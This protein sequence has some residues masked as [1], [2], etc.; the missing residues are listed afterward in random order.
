MSVEDQ[1]REM[2]RRVEQYKRREGAKLE[3]LDKASQASNANIAAF[4][5]NAYFE[6]GNNTSVD[7]ARAALGVEL[8]KESVLNVI[9]A[10]EWKLTVSHI[11]QILKL[12]RNDMIGEH[13][14]W[15]AWDL[16]RRLLDEERL[17]RFPGTGRSY[18]FGTSRA[19][20]MDERR[21]RQE[22]GRL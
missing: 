20:H 2:A 5:D 6:R 14:T 11:S 15:L 19:P 13:K 4:E 8:I 21:F 17:Y 1:I 3:F 10:H 18:I 16:V 9:R 22:N 12:D 7:R